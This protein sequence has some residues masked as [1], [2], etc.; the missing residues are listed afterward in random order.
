MELGL[1]QPVYEK[2]VYQDQWG[3]TRSAYAP[4]MD[5]DSQVI[6][7]LGVD[8]QQEDYLQRINMMKSFSFLLWMA[9][10][11]VTLY[12]SYLFTREQE[13]L[14]S[15]VQTQEIIKNEKKIS[16]LVR[17]IPMGIYRSTPGSQGKIVM[18][19]P[20]FAKIFGYATE[21]EVKNLPVHNFYYEPQSR[22]KFEHEIQDGN[23][24]D[25]VEKLKRKDGKKIWGRVRAQIVYREDGAIDY[26]DASIEDITDSKRIAKK[27]KTSEENYRLVVD[28]AYEAIFVAQSGKVAFFNSTLGEWTGYTE[29]ELKNL[30]IMDLIHTEDRFWVMNNYYKRMQGEKVDNNYVFRLFNKTGEIVWVR[31]N[32]VYIDWKG[33]PATLNFLT[34]ISSEKLTEGKLHV[35]EERYR[36]MVRHMPIGFCRVIADSG[37][38]VTINEALIKMLGY[39]VK[40]KENLK[41]QNVVNFYY[42]KSNRDFLRQKL[43]ENGKII[44]QKLCIKDRKGDPFWVNLNATL[45]KN[46]DETVIDIILQDV[47]ELRLADQKIQ[48][49]YEILRDYKLAIE[50][51]SN[52]IVITGNGGRIEYV[53][54]GFEQNMGYQ[55]EEVIGKNA[56]LLQA[57][58][59]QDPVYQEIT[60]TLSRNEVWGGEL[61][62]KKKNGEKIWE[63]AT[64]TPIFD[65]NKRT[66]R[67]ITVKE[68]ITKERQLRENLQISYNKLKE[69]DQRKD[70]FLSVA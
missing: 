26:Y 55:R 51:T 47:N 56:T 35:T 11:L 49:Q 13:S 9:L 24:V 60:E 20:A 36:S 17:N 40:D 28:N 14:R 8:I 29:A 3:A 7:A 10:A 53:N 18:A 23:A 31:I 69:L 30:D 5:A 41:R 38:I 39:E 58:N 48:A 42:D 19:N 50:N 25:M 15:E 34:N 2:T 61:Y 1:I 33:H 45:M 66:Y 16:D 4:I 12:L 59:P 54:Q 43:A 46:E 65:D 44:N 6:A 52:S 64:V 68:N 21:E 67:Y 22:R 57:V 62:N 27:L 37:Q 32:V 63:R 70:T